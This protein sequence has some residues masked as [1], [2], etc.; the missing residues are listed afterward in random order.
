MEF[1][2]HPLYDRSTAQDWLSL[3]PLDWTE[4][5][6]GPEKQLHDL[7]RSQKEWLCDLALSHIR[8]FANV[9]F[10]ADTPYPLEGDFLFI[11][12]E[13]A[14]YKAYVEY[15]FAAQADGPRP[16]SDYWWVILGCPYP[17]APYP[18]GRREGYIDGLGWY[19]L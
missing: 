5:E 17:V 9:S 15:A 3:R 16:D 7:V 19:V 8:G 4:L 13:D 11:P 12:V 14:G 6:P 10:L 18:T 2:R 1:L